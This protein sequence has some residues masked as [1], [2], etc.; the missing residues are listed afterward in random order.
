MISHLEF[1]WRNSCTLDSYFTWF[2]VA[3]NINSIIRLD[4]HF[5]AVKF[6]SINIRQIWFASVS[7]DF[8]SSF[9]KS[10]MP[11]KNEWIF[12]VPFRFAK[13]SLLAD[14]SWVLCEIFFFWSMFNKTFHALD[15]EKLEKKITIKFL[16]W[17]YEIVL[18][19]DVYFIEQRKSEEKKQERKS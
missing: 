4:R 3:I 15:V 8:L 17:K 10:T 11:F 2:W 19:F 1:G 6:L 12:L 5:I 14:L 7:A 9:G 13:Q 18:K 16:S